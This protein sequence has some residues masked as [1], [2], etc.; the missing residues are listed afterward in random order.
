MINNNEIKLSVEKGENLIPK[1]VRITENK[2]IDID[3]IELNHPTL[4]E[5]FIKYTGRKISDV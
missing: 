3:S 2:N 1:I 4:E 5:V